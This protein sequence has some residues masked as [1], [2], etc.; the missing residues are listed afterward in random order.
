MDIQDFATILKDHGVR[1]ASG[2]PCSY[3]TPLVNA[4]GS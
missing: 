4:M 1:R 2:V 3:F